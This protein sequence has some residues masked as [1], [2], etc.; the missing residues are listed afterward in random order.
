MS[1][2]VKVHRLFLNSWEMIV[3]PFAD[4]WMGFYRERRQQPFMI[5]LDKLAV[6]EDAKLAV[7]RTV[8]ALSAVAGGAP[9]DSCLE[10]LDAWT[11]DAPPSR[12]YR[13]PKFKLKHY[14]GFAILDTG[15]HFCDTQNCCQSGLAARC[16]AR[17]EVAELADAHGS[18]PCTRK[19]VEVQVLSSAPK[20]SSSS[21]MPRIGRLAQDAPNGAL[22]RLG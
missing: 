13:R 4:G 9:I 2:S 3:V 7:C 15:P 18:G 17:A 10:S 20:I 21:Q 16:N 12:T 11:E 14:Q 8:Q 22:L 1:Q 19:G 5:A 6:L